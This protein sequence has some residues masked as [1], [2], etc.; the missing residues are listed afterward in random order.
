MRKKGFTLT[1]LLVVLAIMAL[2]A[3]ISVPVISSLTEK[4]GLT[5]D[6]TKADE[7]ELSIDLWMHTDYQDENF[8]RTNLYN[9][10][11]T[12]EAAQAKIG[13]KTEQMYSYYYAGTDQLPGVELKNESQIRHS[14]I[15]A[16]KATSGM[17]TIIQGAEQ[18][19][20][21]PK[22]GAQYGFKYYY[23]IGRVNVEHIDAT[24]SELGPDDVYKYYVWLD[25]TGGNISASTRIKNYKY[26]PDPE[27][28][29]ETFGHFVFNFGSVNLSTV[30][31][32]I[33]QEGK[34]SYTFA[35]I[36]T[37]PSIFPSGS[38]DIYC[39]KDGVLTATKTGV[40]LNGRE[41]T[42]DLR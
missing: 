8:F 5:A 19:I 11:S 26:D 7:I 10:S 37:T 31:I 35:G 15:T 12:G 3:L 38:Y 29:E 42:V 36:P 22:A 32:I 1:E 9:S 41:A 25:R 14:A 23:K 2:M 24:E 30:R 39:Y 34:Q 20:E 27:V 17:K 28:S 33:K 16:I 18:F 6:R 13:G 21:P 4:S 40:E